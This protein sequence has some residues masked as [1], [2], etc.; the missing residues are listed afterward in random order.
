MRSSQERQVFMEGFLYD[1][2]Q[3]AKLSG[4]STRTLRYYDQ[5]GLLKPAGTNA[6]G[7]RFYSSAEL[8]RLQ[9]ILFFKTLGVELKE[10]K[11]LLDREDSD[12]VA[13]LKKQKQ[14]L[15]RRREA[16]DKL[17]VN[18][19]KTIH[20]AEGGIP[21]SD[22]ERFEG[23][24]KELIEENEK[25]YGREIREKY[26][27]ESIESANRKLADMTKEEYKDLQQI[28]AEMISLL[29]EAMK[30]GDPGNEKAQ[31]A[32]AL[33][34]EWICRYWPQ[35]TKEA[36]IELADLYVN[37]E[38]FKAYYDEKQP[39]LAQF[40]RDAIHKWLE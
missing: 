9:R 7:Y 30:T 29:K 21:M 26:G 15:I 40:L 6:A 19:E 37:D 17:I 35:Y 28:E 27:E 24:K 10:I 4:V 32:A 5:I 39:G 8:K 36:H 16:L 33:H 34:K 22:Q 3:A 25:K 18:L 31:K 2:Q 38:R 20:E 11:T 1:I 13:V 12:P 23:F 14:E